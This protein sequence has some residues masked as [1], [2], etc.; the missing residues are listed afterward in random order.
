MYCES[1]HLYDITDL[2]L[3][4]P[5]VYGKETFYLFQA[6]SHSQLLIYVLTSVRAIFKISLVDLELT[7]AFCVHSL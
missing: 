3:K 4:N 5:A 1:T 2:L 7:A 6:F